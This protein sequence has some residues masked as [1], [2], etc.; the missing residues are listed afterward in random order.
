VSEVFELD[1]SGEVTVSGGDDP[2]IDFTR[3]RA[4]DR[5]YHVV[6]EHTQQFG[7]EQVGHVP[8]FI[9][10]QRASI[11]Q[12]EASLLAMFGTREGTLDMPEQSGFSQF[13][14]DCGTVHR[15]ERALAPRPTEMDGTSDELLARAAFTEDEHRGGVGGVQPSDILDHPADGGALPHETR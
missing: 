13:G 12:F 15:Y 14:W 4:A 7:L 10:E 9:K 6:V 1:F 2:H 3:L 5:C 11:G 8:D